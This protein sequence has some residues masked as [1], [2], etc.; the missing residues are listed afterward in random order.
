M[1]DEEVVFNG[2]LNLIHKA[3][4]L[5]KPPPHNL[6]SLITCIMQ[7]LMGLG[8]NGIHELTS[9]CKARIITVAQ[10]QAKYSE[11]DVKCKIALNRL[12]A[13][14][15]LPQ[16]EELGTFS[17]QKIIAYKNAETNTLAHYRLIKNTH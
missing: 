1:K 10:L 16:E 15:N 12:A 8:I 2:D 17:I 5:D 3:L 6:S 14:A 4:S 9:P 7:P 11:I 13:L